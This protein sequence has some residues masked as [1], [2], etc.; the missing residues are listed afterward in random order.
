MLKCRMAVIRRVTL[1]VLTILVLSTSQGG[2][3]S[4]K[5]PEVNS[6]FRSFADIA[7]KVKPAVVNISTTSTVKV[8]AN[9]LEQFLGPNDD[10]PLSEFFKRNFGENGEREMKQQSLGSGSIINKDGLILT[11]NHVVD[12]AEEIKVKLSDGREFKAKVIGRDAKTDL[13]LIK[14]ASPFENLPVL[15]LGDSDRMRVGDWVIAVGNPFGLEET[16]THGIISGTARVIGSGPYDNF[17]QTD[18][19]INPGNSGGPLV[20]VTGEVI[21]INTIIVSGGQGL[22]FAVPSTLASSVVDQLKE[23]GKVVRGWMGV[24]IQN[25]S[26]PIAKAFGL[27]EPKGALIAD[28][29]AGGPADKGGMKS[30]DIITSFD[31]KE[32]KTAND[33]SRVVAG[34]AVGKEIKGTAIRDGKEIPFTMKVEEL[35]EERTASKALPPL[36][37]FGMKLE[38]MTPKL[39]EQLKSEEKTGVVVVDVEPGSFADDA[40]IKPGD[41]VREIN[42]KPVKNLA[43]Y[44]AEAEKIK[45]GEPILLLLKRGKQTF[46]IS[47]E[48]S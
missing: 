20:N 36:H 5:K 34:T 25:V 28:V 38:D 17:L 2:C 30:G 9:P 8:P 44:R 21:G 4:K 18:A 39:R 15:S 45:K 43:E 11:T 23:K 27:K 24:S 31:G 10:S 29:I 19:P 46:Y 22:G 16:V 3:E 12:N 37:G 40:G 1:L 47:I 35:T 42:R 32:I 7:E 33:L 26:P 14:I 13:A 6:S 48:K 41:V